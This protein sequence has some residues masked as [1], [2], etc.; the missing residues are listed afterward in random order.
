MNALPPPRLLLI[1]C[2]LLVAGCATRP[3]NPPLTEVDSGKP[4]FVERKGQTPAQSQ[5]LVVLAFSGGGTRAAAFSYGVLET[6]RRTEIQVKTGQQVRLLD[7]VDA[8]TGVSGGSFT[9]L[10]YRLYGEKLFDEYEKR[11][12]K[13]NVQG[14]LVERALNPFNWGKLSSTGWGRSEL[15]ANLYDEILFNG[16]TFADLQRIDGPTIAVSATDITSGARVVF[17]P[18]NFDVMCADLGPI[19]IAR[20]AASSSAVPVVLSPMTFNNYGGRCGYRWPPWTKQFVDNPN[21][22]RPAA[23]VVKRLLE[24]QELAEGDEPYIHLVDG[25]VSDN[26]G[27]R[28][29]LDILELFEALHEAGQHTPLDHVRRIVVFIVNS[30]SIPSTDWARVEDA[31]GTIPVLIKSAGVPIDRYSGEQVEQLRDIEARWKVLRQVRDSSS[32][33]KDSD[34]AMAFVKNAPDAELYA[35]DVSFAGLKDKAEREYLNQLPTSFVLTD[36][37]VD[38]LRA[39][40]GKIILDSP[41]FQ[42]LLKDVGAKIV[43]APAAK[44]RN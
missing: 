43:D 35:I 26:L 27:L 19:R 12:L 17:T 7:Q 5:N 4:Y 32:F 1:A 8:I 33:K 31:P 42:R 38:R 15:A 16:T 24:L 18:Q 39:A 9:A 13:R 40:A 22:P 29:V 3:I 20:A 36:E 11:F 37:Q 28:S 2:V 6:L 44:P 14:E 10:A 41:D 21:P 30:L 25:G 23:R 34:P